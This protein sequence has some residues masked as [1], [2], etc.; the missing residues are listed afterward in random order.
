MIVSPILVTPSN[1]GLNLHSLTISKLLGGGQA[2][3]S[4]PPSTGPVP[5]GQITFSCMLSEGKSFKSPKNLCP[6]S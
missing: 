5:I 2:E 1:T 6:K 3:A 4:Q